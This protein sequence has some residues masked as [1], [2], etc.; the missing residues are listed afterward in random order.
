MYTQPYP[1]IIYTF[2]NT[3]IGTRAHLANK[4][5]FQNSDNTSKLSNQSTQSSCG[6]HCL[7]ECLV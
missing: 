6:Y 5:S 1:Q 7:V 2:K 3:S 4:M